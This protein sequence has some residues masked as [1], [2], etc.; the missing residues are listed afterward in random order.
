MKL[1]AGMLRQIIK[2]E[3]S[4]TLSENERVM[5]MSS[6]SMEMSRAEAEEW[7]RSC[8]PRQ[9]LDQDIFDPETGE[10]YAHAGETCGIAQQ[11]LNPSPKSSTMKSPDSY[12][13]DYNAAL[14]KFAE[15]WGDSSISDLDPQ[16]VAPDIARNFFS[17]YPEWEMW[18]DELD[19]TEEEILSDVTDHVYEAMMS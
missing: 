16:D 11:R 8:D 12:W 5:R 17:E 15:E 19:L 3:V 13:D 14:R 7:L 18:S 1:T 10:I 9:V 6:E 2:E 4:R